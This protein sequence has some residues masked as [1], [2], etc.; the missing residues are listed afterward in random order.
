MAI[1]RTYEPIATAT[2]GSTS[3]TFNSIPS[4]YT[5]LILVVSGTAT[6]SNINY[7]LRFNGDSGSNYSVTRLYGSGTSAS[8]DRL[9]NFTN[10]LSSNMTD[11]ANTVIHHIMNYSNTSTYK[12]ALVRSNTGTNYVWANVAMWRSTAAINSIQYFT[13]AS[14][15]MAS[16]T[17][18]LYGIKAA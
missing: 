4:T 11:G 3:Y 15:S 12:T 16:G 1:A 18:T 5:D 8:N 17:L 10:T 6:G 13:T 7:G 2:S 9:A 14:G